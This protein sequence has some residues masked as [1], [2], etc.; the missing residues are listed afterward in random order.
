MEPSAMVIGSKRRS[1]PEQY[2]LGRTSSLKGAKFS[3]PD[4][5]SGV[6]A[7]VLKGE[8]SLLLDTPERLMRKHLDPSL[9]FASLEALAAEEARAYDELVGDDGLDRLMAAEISEDQ[10]KPPPPSPTPAKPCFGLGLA[11][12][13]SFGHH[14][15]EAETAKTNAMRGRCAA[16]I[17]R[18]ARRSFHARKVREAASSHLGI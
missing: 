12:Q 9:S 16:A 8:L 18:L 13:R 6:A 15:T 14:L 4:S 1:D 3:H 2:F 7:S 17:G 5:D 11:R 10:P